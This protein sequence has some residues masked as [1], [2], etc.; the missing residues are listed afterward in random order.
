M[1]RSVPL[2]QVDAFSHVPFRGN[3]AAVCL[4]DEPREAAWMQSIAAEMNL[5]ETAFVWRERGAYGLRWFTPAVEVPLC[6]HATLASAHVL[7]E[8]GREKPDAAIAFDTLSG[9][10]VA[11]RESDWIRLDFPALPPRAEAPPPPGLLAALGLAEARV[12]EVPR[13]AAS[14]G[15]SFLVEV[16]S[17]EALRAVEPDFRALARAPGHAVIVTARGSGEYDFVSRFFAP[18]AGVDED[19][20]TG[21]AHCSLAPYWCARLGRSELTGLQ[22][23]QRSGVVRVR[24]RGERVDLLGRALT[25][26]R[27]ELCA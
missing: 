27:G 15:P 17:A 6:G 2:H 23:S 19:P 3:P 24:S 22:L 8:T 12:C 10:L 13:P 14:D 20:V 11:V 7:Y 9:R 5:A 26:L 21:S 16:E 1:N 18:K 4:L 25:V